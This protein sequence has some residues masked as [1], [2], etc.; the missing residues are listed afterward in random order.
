[1]KKNITEEQFKRA[2]LLIQRSFASKVYFFNKA[3]SDWLRVLIKKG[4]FKN[5]PMPHK[6]GEYLRFPYWPESQYLAKIASDLPIEVMTVLKKCKLSKLSNPRI[7]EDFLESAI[8]MPVD[9]GINIIEKIQREKWIE[10]PYDFMISY[11]INEFLKKII[12]SKKYDSALD[13]IKIILDVKLRKPGAEESVVGFRNVVGYIQPYE[14]ENILKTTS[15]IPISETRPFIRMLT[16]L[17][18]K[19]VELEIN[20]RQK[21]RERISGDASFIWRPAI[22]ESV[23]NWGT[24][25]IKE[26][27][28]KYIRDLITRYMTWLKEK[29]KESINKEL[30]WLLSSDPLYAIL[31]RLKLHIY[32]NFIVDFKKQIEIAIISFF[33]DLEVWHEYALLVSEAYENI[34]KEIRQKYLALIEEGPKGDRNEDNIRNWKLRNLA[35]IK[36]YL[37]SEQLSEY[38]KSLKT[39]KGPEEPTFLAT[40][41]SWIGPTSPMSEVDVLEMSVD[42]VI[43]YLLNWIPPKDFFSP[44]P[45]GLGRIISSTIEKQTDKYS[46]D[47]CKFLNVKLRPVYVFHF[48]WGLKNGLKK[49]GTIYWDQVVQTAYKIIKKAINNDLA[50][51]EK[52]HDELETEWDGVLKAIADLLELG[53]GQEKQGPHIKHKDKIFKIID[54][55]CK[56]EDPTEEY[57]HKYGGENIDPFTM[58]INTVRGQA[59]HALFSYMF[60]C[61]RMSGENTVNQ[62]IIPDEVKK[63]LKRHLIIKYEKSLTIRSV[64]GRYLP[65]LY[66]ID[67][68]WTEGIL[69]NLFPKRDRERRYAA[70][71]T[72]LSNNVFSAVY[73]ALKNEYQ[74]AIEE[75]ALQKPKRSYWSNPEER[76]AEHVIIGYLFGFDSKENSLFNQFFERANSNQ[77]GSAIS[78]VGR[79]YLSSKNKKKKIEKLVMKKIKS[80]WKSRLKRSSD[81][82]ELMEFGWWIVKDR[83]DNQWML[84][85]ANKTL[86]KTRGII[87]PNFLVMENLC[88]LANDFPSLVITALHLIVKSGFRDITLRFNTEIQNIL[89]KVYRLGDKKAVDLADEIKDYLLKL[90]YMEYRTVGKTD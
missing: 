89:K 64:Y 20:V 75:L 1:M 58:S 37:S 41:T 73:N 35:L 88:E 51:F 7:M 28:V 57:E 26:L 54:F 62:S 90:G 8:N 2:E 16:Q 82:E 65:W 85:Q 79:A 23:Q 77:R 14:Y 42:D 15:N 17:L 83:F 49:G 9:I 19:A 30:E 55:L 69:T 53:L 81:I 4:F 31:T 12:A 59:F 44:S 32:R 25:E 66:L 40:H 74:V 3:S 43:Q 5:P 71:E 10:S 11:R 47:S 34:D 39:L 52:A 22:E 86:E 76:L 78:Y 61:N 6:E 33:G 45:E 56:H 84:E 87:Y 68:K 50:S 18:I 60:W 21:T 80:M 24:L 29:R 67:K 63:I 13:L 36:K 72:Y 27:L 46:K 48:F 38:E 70:W